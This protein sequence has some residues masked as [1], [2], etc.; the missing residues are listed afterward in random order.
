VVAVGSAIEDC[1]T[2]HEDKLLGPLSFFDTSQMVE[3][4]L[5]HPRGKEWRRL[6]IRVLHF[7]PTAQ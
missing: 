7:C 1:G 4:M 2:D 5:R 6:R 3:P